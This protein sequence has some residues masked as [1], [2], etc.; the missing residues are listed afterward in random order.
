MTTFGVDFNSHLR[1][2]QKHGEYVPYI[3]SH[4]VDEINNRGTSHNRFHAI[5]CRTK[6]TS[7]YY[8]KLMRYAFIFRVA[9]QGN[10]QIVWGEIKSRK[11]LSGKKS[12]KTSLY[13]CSFLGPRPRYKRQISDPDHQAKKC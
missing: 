3:V 2:T 8:L 12:S 5:F 7:K 13:T 10:L 6:K 1:A 11:S 9:V 4:C